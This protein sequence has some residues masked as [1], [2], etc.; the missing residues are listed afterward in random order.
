M[1]ASDDWL[2]AAVAKHLAWLTDDLIAEHT[3]WV[4]QAIAFPHGDHDAYSRRSKRD[5]RIPNQ[6]APD[7]VA[8]IL[9]N[10][11]GGTASRKVAST[12]NQRGRAGASEAVTRGRSQEARPHAKYSGPIRPF[13]VPPDPPRS[14]GSRPRVTGRLDVEGVEDV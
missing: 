9:G 2:P 5:R 10:D 14:S 1:K 8:R 4:E 7:L 12:R 11:E 13:P 6:T 3:G